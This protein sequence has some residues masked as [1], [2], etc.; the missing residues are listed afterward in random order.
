MSLHFHSLTVKDIRRETDD[1]I[2]V[3]FDIPPSLENDF[4]FEHGQN[5]TIRKLINGEELRRNYSICTSPDDKELRVA[6]KAMPF[7]RFSTWA[8]TSLKQGDVLEVMPPTGKFNSP[9]DPKATKNYL[10][11]AAGSGIT[12]VMSILKTVLRAEP[13]SNFTLVYGNRDRRSIIFREELENLKNKYIGRLQLVH[14]LS[15]EQPEAEI[16]HGRIDGNKCAELC[17][18]LIDI[19]SYDEVFICGPEQMIFTVRDY[20]QSKGF[21]EEHIHFELFTSSAQVTK[22]TEQKAQSANGE[23]LSVIQVK[24][25]GVVT[26]FELPVQGDTILNAALRHGADLPFA[27]KGGMCSTCRAKLVEGKVDMDVNY[28]LEKDEV[29][30]GFILT[31]QSHPLTP[32]VFVDFDQR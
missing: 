26:R 14:I 2:S 30:A 1:C 4:R 28:A 3:A 19:E 7:G 6:I 22:G 29:A 25:D 27:C 17:G 11:F 8:N 9:L 32:H 12:P 10:A 16:L 24:I 13:A 23:E 5:I 20:L 15:R 31:C 21:P 18:H